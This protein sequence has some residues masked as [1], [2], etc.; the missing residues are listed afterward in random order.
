VN[1]RSKSAYTQIG[2][3]YADFQ[4][5]KALAAAQS[6]DPRADE[7]VRKW[8]QIFN[9]ILTGSVDYG[10]RAPLPDTPVWATPEGGT[11]GFV[12]GE[13][14]ASGAMQEHELDLT[15][16]DTFADTGTRTTLN[17][18]HLSESGLALLTR[19]L[20]SG[21][22]R[23]NVPEEGA[24]LT[25][26]WL[27]ANN[28]S[29]SARQL[30]E[31]IGPW[32]HKLRFYPVP[33]A[34]ALSSG[35]QAFRWTVD[36]VKGSLQSRTA[37]QQIDVQRE[38]ITVWAPLLDE[39]I[40]LCLQTADGDA[41]FS[42]TKIKTTTQW[43]DDAS[44]LL[45]RIDAAKLA[46]RLCKKPHK[47]KANFSQLVK[48][49]R[50]YLSQ[51][52]SERDI[53]RAGV[54]LQRCI[55][56]RGAPHSSK[57]SQLRTA[58]ARQ[59]QAPAYSDIAQLLTQRLGPLP[60]QDGVDQLTDITQAIQPAEANSRVPA[61]T[62]IPETLLKVVRRCER[63][64]VEKLVE[65][66][67]IP[68]ADTLAEV[69]P[70]ISAGIRALGLSDANLR[71]LY[72]S[73]YQ[74]FRR[75][76]SLLL[77]NLESQVRI[78]EL[79]WITAIEKQRADELNAA[80]I[81]K[82]T[83]SE[84]ALLTLT[85]FPHAIIP[86]KLLQ[87]MRALADGAGIE[88][89]LTDELAT[90]IFMGTFTNKFVQASRIAADCLSD[91]L[92]A[93]YYG[94]DYHQIA[95]LPDRLPTHQ[96]RSRGSPRNDFTELVE[97]RAGVSAGGWN[98]ADNGMLIEQQQILTTH[99]LAPITNKL[100][101]TDALTVQSISLAQQIFQW[102]LKRLQANTR[103]WHDWLIAIKNCA[104]AWR[105]MM[106]FLSLSEQDTVNQFIS[107]ADAELVQ[108]A[109][110]FQHAFQPALIGLKSAAAGVTP[111]VKPGKAG[112]QFLGW[113]NSRHWLI[114]NLQDRPDSNL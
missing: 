87:E 74:A 33:A 107:W 80:E 113:T 28:Q 19:L 55:A 98:T 67:V 50:R 48:L 44:D 58:Q 73:I 7:R 95:Q 5:A 60:N 23:I 100:E 105:Q 88:I 2:S 104:Y 85:A 34:I 62:P 72:T 8:Q 83:F 93:T 35:T 77:T 14:L 37:N 10:S 24:L 108:N 52:L 11:G 111:P 38:A 75:R 21:H 89:P 13:L 90:D 76:R 16:A 42:E 53:R 17:I 101:L 66:G 84:I 25:V 71:R 82:Q 79:P 22:Y 96:S 6:G 102:I 32:F 103:S 49:L 47:P 12:T 114:P 110:E 9:N 69:L 1:N 65:S 56:R 29:D 36:Q 4:L 59:T 26:A 40:D 68:S 18:N 54:L 109:A 63:N 41:L 30:L 3:A 31:A 97:L 91:S 64:T 20:E 99:N 46:H 15:G 70:Q 61:Y 57:L 92:Y 27:T 51:G 39:L 45:A 81:S 112:V 94:I 86:N 78:E 43:Q 106:F